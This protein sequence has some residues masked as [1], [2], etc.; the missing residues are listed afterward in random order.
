MPKQET[1]AVESRTRQSESSKRATFALLKNK[2]R[3]QREV[4]LRLPDEDG[5]IQEVSMLFRS[6]GSQDYDKLL[7]KNPPTTEQKADGGSYNVNTFGPDLLSHVCVE[8]EMSKK[9]W[10]EVW[11]SA[12]WNRG[13]IMQLFLVAVELCNKGLDI[14]FSE[15]D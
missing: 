4:V 13:E 3:S 14:P 11:N 8:P 10:L 7:T 12:D 6:I 2:P 9:D 1:E 5:E 15:T